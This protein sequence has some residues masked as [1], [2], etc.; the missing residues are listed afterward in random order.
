MTAK[1]VTGSRCPQCRAGSCYNSIQQGL[2]AEVMADVALRSFL[3]C[4]D[5]GAE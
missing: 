4:E 2:V 5:P 3:D 1:N